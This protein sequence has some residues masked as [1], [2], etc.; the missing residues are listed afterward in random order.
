MEKTNRSNAQHLGENLSE[1]ER[2]NLVMFENMLRTFSPELFYVYVSM[3]K[4]E[5]E[6]K[7]VADIV[8]KVGIVKRLDDGFGK[9]IV[10]MQR[11][12][13]FRIRILQDKIVK[14]TKDERQLDF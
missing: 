5:I 7:E 4:N 13:I 11:H 6:P 2:N 14:P 10:E 9:I 8:H 3:R 1:E 12:D